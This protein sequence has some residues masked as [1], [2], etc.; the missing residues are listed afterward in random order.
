MD[1]L[2]KI[3]Q[4]SEYVRDLDRFI[5]QMETDYER[6][7]A[8]VRHHKAEIPKLKRER[9]S[10]GDKINRLTDKAHREAAE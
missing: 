4:L 10:L 2:R 3:A 8:S 9:K 1:E 6:D 7:L 5:A